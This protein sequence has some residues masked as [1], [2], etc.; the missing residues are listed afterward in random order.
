MGQG[1]GFLAVRLGARL[2]FGAVPVES[3]V[4]IVGPQKWAFADTSVDAAGELWPHQPLAMLLARPRTRERGHMVLIRT[5]EGRVALEVEEGVAFFKSAGRARPAPAAVDPHGHLLGYLPL[6]ALERH[7][8]MKAEAANRLARSLV[9][10][11]GPLRA[12]GGALWAG[13][14]ALEGA[15]SLVDRVQEATGYGCTIFHEDVRVATTVRR[16]GSFERAVG[17]R[18]GA[19]VAEHTLGRGRTFR[20]VTRTLGR[21]WAIVYSPLVDAKRNPI[22]MLATFAEVSLKV[23]PVFDTN[24][25]ARGFPDC[26]S[27]D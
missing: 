24:A 20:G 16:I 11:H 25:I 18:A 4:R 3:I 26:S 6:L 12:D 15:Y 21:D 19:G 10:M 22:G 2:D 1:L 9:E 14:T 27:R 23:F 17:T 7:L 13:T 8:V 5:R